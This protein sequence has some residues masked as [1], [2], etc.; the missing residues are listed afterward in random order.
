MVSDENGELSFDYGSFGPPLPIGGVPPPNANAPT[1][2]G[3]AD[4]GTYNIATGVVRIVL[5]VSKAE[6]IMA[7]Q[8]L[9]GLNVRT[10]FNRPDYPG[11]Q[12]S[13]NNASD[14][15][16]D[17]SYTVVGNDLPA[18][19]CLANRLP[20]AALSGNPTSGNSPL[21]VNF[22][23]SESS[24]PDPGDSIASTFSRSVTGRPILSRQALRSPTP[25]L[26]PAHPI[27]RAL[28]ISSPRLR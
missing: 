15:T 17:G 5:D 22:N 7:G 26:V 27:V 14:I 13:Q 2:I 6:N 4:S 25:T 24:D 16:A 19:G 20:I 18:P 9:A 1:R 10:Y 3:P 11:F 21:V 12:R 23:G 8:T 28:A